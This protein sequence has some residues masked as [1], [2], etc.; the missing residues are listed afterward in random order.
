MLFR[1]AA[2]GEVLH[3]FTKVNVPLSHETRARRR[4]GRRVFR[5]SERTKQKGPPEGGPFRILSCRASA[6]GELEALA[7][8]G[9]TVFLPFHHAAV[10]GK[11]ARGLQRAA[12]AG[13]VKLQRL[14]D[15]V[16][17]GTCLTRK[18][19]ALDG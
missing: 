1:Y 12:Q 19:A 13:F 5:H 16:L 6:L 17:D 18:P 10:A 4:G 3:R 11:E 8:L 2:A 15:A 14:G 9:A 7:R